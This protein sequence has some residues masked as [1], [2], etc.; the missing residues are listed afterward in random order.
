MTLILHPSYFM[1]VVTLGR[2]YKASTVLLDT[3]DSYVKQTYRNRCLIAGANGTL[4]LNIPIVHQGSGSSVAYSTIEIDHSQSWA[5]THLKS[6]GSAYRSSPY[7]EYYEDDLKELFAHIP[8]QLT[9][10]NVKTM[11]WLCDLL[12][13]PTDWAKANNYTSDPEATYLIIAKKEYLETLP[14]YAQ[15]FQEKHGFT[16]HLSALDLLFNLGPSS[17]DYLKHIETNQ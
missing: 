13:I 2:L 17:R 5:S 10:W 12:H 3:N 15:V 1:D 4:N 16:P 8:Q 11:K 7:F 9:D 6:I 14:A